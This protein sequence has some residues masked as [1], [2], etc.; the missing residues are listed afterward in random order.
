MNKLIALITGVMLAGVAAAQEHIPSRVELAFN[1]YYDS[2]QMAEAMRQ[3][4]DAYP[5]LVELRNI[6]KSQQGR[7]MWLA[8]VN[9]KHGRPDTEKPAMFIDGNIHGNEIQGGEVVLYTLWYLTKAYGV[10]EHLT[11]LMDECAFYLLPVENPD[12]R[13]W[14]FANVASPHGPR[15]NQR[16]YDDDRDGLIDEDGP[17]DLDGD[18]SITQ[19]WKPDPE[20]EWIRDRFDDRI[21]RRVEPGQKGDWTRL[22]QEGIDNDGDGRINEDDT[23]AD[24]MNRNWPTDWKPGYA[25]YGAGLYPLSAPEVRAIADFVAAHPNIAAYQ[26]YHNNGGMILRG[27]GSADRNSFYPRADARVYDLIA[28]MGEKLLPYYRSMVIYRDLYGVHGGEVNW[29]AESLGIIAFTN[30]LWN[31]GKY[32][33]RETPADD[34]NMW[35]WRDRLDFGQTF[36]PYT[37][38]DHP[39]YGRVLV[40]GLNKW[41]AR[42]TPTFMLE[43]EC[44]RNFAFTMFHAGQMPKL[45][46]G[47]CTLARLGPR[48][49]DLTVAIENEHAIPTRTEV[50]S[51]NGI[52]LRDLLEVSLPQGARVVTSGRIAS[53][54][55]RT[56]D[57]VKFEPERIL[58]DDGVPGR[59]RL[60]FRF[61]IEAD[62]GVQGTVRFISQK[63][64]DIERPITMLIEP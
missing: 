14:W 32:F 7:D 42:V 3:I 2:D 43:E 50:M 20:G 49:W 16:P 38:V 41:A 61:I 33:Q 30:E 1:R 57:E 19:M 5:E 36:T 34:A 53:R 58:L 4:A 37:W 17:D 31:E 56:I 28:E 44:H 55:E 24:D 47:E 8:I 54:L 21:F 9:P 13:A 35:I 62:E 22:G 12:S 6:G 59:G 26:S 27:P 15:G 29:A 46:F 39:Q 40:G 23:T 10:N 18:G 63:A 11:E 45:R 64:L 51:R 25:Q 60:L 52:G 48:L